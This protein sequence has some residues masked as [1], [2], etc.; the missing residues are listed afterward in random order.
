MIKQNKKFL[1][2]VVGHKFPM[3]I[4]MKE[5]LNEI[6]QFSQYHKIKEFSNKTKQN[7]QKKYKIIL[8]ISQNKRIF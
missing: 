2:K 4:K 7:F 5:F 8:S 1:I 3:N 6:K